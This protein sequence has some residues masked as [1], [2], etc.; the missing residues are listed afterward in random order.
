MNVFH[1]EIVSPYSK[2][3]KYLPSRKVEGE[4]KSL[5]AENLA[6]NNDL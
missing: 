6:F 1:N 5:L 3:N 2:Q 4:E